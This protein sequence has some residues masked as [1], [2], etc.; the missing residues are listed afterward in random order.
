M[1][2]IRFNMLLGICFF[3]LF[4]L[5]LRLLSLEMPITAGLIPRYLHLLRIGSL[6]I[7]NFFAPPVN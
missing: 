2:N 7:A 4:A 3:L 1:K 5:G 6:L